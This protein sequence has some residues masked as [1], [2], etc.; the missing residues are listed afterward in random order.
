LR[1]IRRVALILVLTAIAIAAIGLAV[2]YVEGRA[3][4]DQSGEY[5]AL[6]SSFA[7]GPQLGP[8][9]KGSPHA[10][11]RTVENYAQQLARTTGL[12]LVDVS[13][14]GATASNILEGGPFFQR[15]QIRALGPSARLV[16]ITIG[17]N[18]VD[19]IGD[20]GMMAFRNRNGVLGSLVRR[21]WKGPRPVDARLFDA[22]V[23]RLIDIV[24]IARQRSPQ[25]TVVLMTYPRVLPSIGTCANVGISERDA[26]LMR[27]VAARLAQATRAAASRSGALLVDMAS[28]SEG[29][30]ACSDDPWTNGSTTAGDG[31]MFHPNWAGMRAAAL[32]LEQ[33]VRQL[34]SQGR[35]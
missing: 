30:D 18:D 32:R 31:A 16:T 17:G 7:A 8:L 35:L 9:V 3:A 4:P 14:G 2:L 26:S 11:W 1:I 21:F 24:A 34:E 23:A 15:P 22:L 33:L 27:E 20:V 29:H 10:C 5:V 6:G 25:A 13:C 12:H 28:E 19:Y